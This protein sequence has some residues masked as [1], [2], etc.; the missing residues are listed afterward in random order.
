[1][2]AADYNPSGILNRIWTIYKNDPESNNK[3][4]KSSNPWKPGM[5]VMAGVANIYT[6]T[7]PH[8]LHHARIPATSDS[9]SGQYVDDIILAGVVDKNPKI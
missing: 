8:P 2:Y 1:M 5:P 6:C 9:A 7:R 4:R 3:S